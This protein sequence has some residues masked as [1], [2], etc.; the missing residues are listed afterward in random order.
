MFVL[1]EPFGVFFIDEQKD[2]QF[3]RTD[4][5][6]IAAVNSFYKIHTTAQNWF[7]AKLECAQEGANLFFAEDDDEQ[8]AVMSLRNATQPDVKRVFVGISNLTSEGEFE[9]IDGTFKYIL[10]FISEMTSQKFTSN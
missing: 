6:Y 2:K 4:Y 7:D 10:H 8:N 3:F 9:T 5:T 1:Y